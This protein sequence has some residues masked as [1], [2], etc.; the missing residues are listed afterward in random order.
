MYQTNQA[1]TIYLLI[2]RTRTSL[3]TR[4]KEPNLMALTSQSTGGGSPPPDASFCDLYNATKEADALSRKLMGMADELADAQVVVKFDSERRHAALSRA[5]LAAFKAGAD[6]SAKAEHVAR[7]SSGY[8]ADMKSLADALA[9]AERTRIAFDTIK[10]RLEVL[11]SMISAEK[12]KME[13]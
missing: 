9:L 6:S 1:R 10:I 2:R 11:R 4:T 13:L 7:G 3:K 5:V 12:A 8:E